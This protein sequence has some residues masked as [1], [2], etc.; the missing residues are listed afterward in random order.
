MTRLARLYAR[1]LRHW[2]MRRAAALHARVELLTYLHA[3]HAVD[4]IRDA[5]RAEIEQH[6]RE[7]ARLWALIADDWRF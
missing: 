4:H 5:M 1:W 7:I 6:E 2:R 3:R